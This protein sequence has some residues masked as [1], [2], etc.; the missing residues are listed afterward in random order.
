MKIFVRAAIHP[1]AVAHLR[2][3]S[4]VQV[5]TWDQPEI[6]TWEDEADA[7]IVR[8]LDVTGDE[9]RRCKKLKVIG[10]HGAG[11]DSVDLA[12]AKEKGII[13]MNTPFENSQSVAELAVTFMLASGRNLGGAMD[14]VRAGRWAEGRKG[15]RCIELFENT[16]GFVGYGRIARMTATI[17]RTAFSMKVLAYDPFVTKEQWAS[18]N[19]VTPCATVKD[20]FAASTYVSIHVPKTK[21][22]MGL[23]N[24]DVFAAAKQGLVLVNT[25]RGGVV[26]E[27]ALYE[28]MKSGIVRAAASDVFEKEP[29]DTASPLLSL[30]NFIATPHYAGATEECLRRVATTIARETIAALF[31]TETPAYRYM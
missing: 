6:A 1:D 9:I 11:V 15:A 5:V 3:D 25:A 2:A 18:M 17:L 14:H 10:R 31:G 30:P 8:G 4:R 27:N 28:A 20:L 26:D 23:I 7:I 13:V 12:A 19:N 16:V 21:D 29:L 22:T 24:A